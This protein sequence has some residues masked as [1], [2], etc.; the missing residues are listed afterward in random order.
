[1]K[2][3]TIADTARYLQEKD[4]FLILT[5]RRPDGDTLGSAAALCLGLRQLGKTAFVLE[6]PEITPKYQFLLE[7]LTKKEAE[8]TDTLVAVDIASKN[9]LPLQYA[10]LAERIALRIDH[11]GTA[12]SFT[13]AELVV[14]EAAA[15][16]QLIYDLL[17][18]MGA[19]LNVPL[20]NALYTAV[21]TDTGCFRYANT[22]SHTF[23]V[24]AAC[25]AVS[26]D[27]YRLNQ[28]LFETNSLARLRIQGW[29]VEN[30][31]FLQQGQICICALPL[32]VENQIGVTEDDMENIS[33]LPRTIDGVKIAATL[34]QE[35]DTG[36][37]KLSVRALP[38][39]DAGAIC[40]K[41]GGGGHKGAAG[42]SLAM[43]MDEAVQ[44]LI[45]AL[46]AIGMDN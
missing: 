28:L 30:A 41:F 19:V 37:I 8:P 24:A 14:P 39:Y 44:A 12:E 32:E 16:G 18:Q 38:Q 3:L 42:A 20:A 34:R 35:R 9:M 36:K 26:P 4:R 2:K 5:H 6:N 21:S 40:A 22:Q 25:A 46:P 17:T 43:S 13:E 10:A 45:Q 27:L 29:M 11:H 15:C 7:D 1:M 23:A 31:R 33:A